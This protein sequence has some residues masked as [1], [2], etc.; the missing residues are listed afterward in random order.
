MGELASGVEEL[1]P[2][3]EELPSRAGV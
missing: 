1:A 2:G 3:V